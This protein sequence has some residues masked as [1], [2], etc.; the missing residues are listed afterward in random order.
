M[1]KQQQIIDVLQGGVQ[2]SE[3]EIF[4]DAFGYNRNN[5]MHSNKKYAEMLR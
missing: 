2:L 1:N 4:I 3:N 5:N